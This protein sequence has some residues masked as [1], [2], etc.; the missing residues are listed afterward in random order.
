MR[1]IYL[2]L[3]TVCFAAMANGQI[4]VTVTGNTNTT[5]NLLATYPSL[6]AAITDLNLVTSMTGPGSF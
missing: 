4:G 6:A 2:L 1:K 5:P 3:L